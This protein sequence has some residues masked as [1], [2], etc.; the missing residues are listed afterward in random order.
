MDDRTDGYGLLLGLRHIERQLR[1]LRAD[2]EAFRD[3]PSADALTEVQARADRVRKAL[4]KL[5]ASA[6]ASPTT[7]LP[8]PDH[9]A[10]LVAGAAFPDRPGPHAVVAASR[11][12]DTMLWEVTRSWRELAITDIDVGLERIVLLLRRLAERCPILIRAAGGTP[13]RSHRR[14]SEPLEYSAP[15]AEL[16]GDPSGERLESLVT[17]MD[18]RLWQMQTDW[19]HMRQRPSPE[20]MHV[21]METFEAAAAVGGELRRNVRQTGN[22]D[23]RRALRVRRHTAEGT[24][25]LPYRDPLTG[26]YNREGFDNLAVAELKR[27]RRYGRPFGLLAIRLSPPDLSGL[28]SAVGCIRAELRE[29]DLLARHTD[30]RIVIGLPEAGAGAAR[31]VAS[32]VIRTL[33]EAHMEP[34]FQR[35]S[36]ASAPEDGATLAGLIDAA[37]ERLRS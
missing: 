4:D 18:G 20:R 5:A 24:P 9:T 21:L 13:D 17:E 6:G 23:V 30:D 10:H 33:R 2:W 16:S 11:Q 27:C 7:R 34:W 28:R 1:R 37:Y 19:Q 22:V 14:G 29:Y 8:E 25:F 32:R 35:L 31:R 3:T 15:S 36:Y 12:I 26:A